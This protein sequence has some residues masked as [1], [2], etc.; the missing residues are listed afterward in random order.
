MAS[1][2]R[3]LVIICFQIEQVGYDAQFLAQF[4]DEDA[5]E[6]YIDAC[7]TH[8]QANYCHESLTSS[9]LVERLDGIIK[10]ED[11]IVLSTDSASLVALWDYTA[12]YVDDADLMLYFAYVGDGYASG[13][14]IAYVGKDFFS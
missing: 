12:T 7:W 6:D 11:G 9:V 3:N 8:L 1:L 14:G 5:A 4:A 2:H 13:G 10:V